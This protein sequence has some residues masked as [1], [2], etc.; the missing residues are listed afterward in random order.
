MIGCPVYEGGFT[1]TTHS[2]RPLLAVGLSLGVVAGLA[3]ATTGSANAAASVDR[4]S[5]AT[6]GEQADAASFDAVPSGDGRY[7]AFTSVANNLSPLDT[8]SFQ[9]DAY[10]RDR[11]TGATELISLGTG[12]AASG[13]TVTDIS[14]DGRYVVFTSAAADLVAND[15]N[16]ANDVFIRDRVA[17]TTEI[18][19]VDS[20]ESA[21]QLSSYDA[22]VSKDGRY[23]AFT[24]MASLAPEDSSSSNQDVYVRD[25]TEGT[26]RL[27]TVTRKGGE[28]GG[29][30]PSISD[31]GR[32]VSFTSKSGQLVKG[33]KNK[34]HDVFVREIA[35]GRTERVSVSS[36]GAEAT[37]RSYESQIAGPGRFVVFT[38][39]AKNL[40]KKDKNRKVD[41]FV[42]DRRKDKTELV[43]VDSA[44]RQ[45]GGPVVT[46]SISADGRYVT[47]NA[48]LDLRKGGRVTDSLY[49]RD[50]AAG[51]TSPLAPGVLKGAV[52]SGDG[53][54]VTFGASRSTVVQPDTNNALDVFAL[55][56]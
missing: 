32:F 17:N 34:L 54:V 23:V 46:P 47:F 33:D 22:S 49:V 51:T 37:K 55:T 20:D 11:T 40:S 2:I 41:V 28:G 36:K 43:S 48:A 35:K 27:V 12:G 10:V 31:N 18:V 9:A 52:L 29:K 21:A 7:V 50:R 8:N 3:G 53:K 16:G 30:Q 45:A 13:G 44:E 19:S 14:A 5:E 42:H 4:V 25:R 56:R 1:L 26:T 15:F 6:G 38:S 24:S 39:M